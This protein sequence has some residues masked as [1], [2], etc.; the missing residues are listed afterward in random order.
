[1]NSENKKEITEYEE[2]LK[3]LRNLLIT[4]LANREKFIINL[5]DFIT[6]EKENYFS[7][8]EKNQAK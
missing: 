6:K 5:G 1:V 7:N 2:K 4:D 8:L 3:E